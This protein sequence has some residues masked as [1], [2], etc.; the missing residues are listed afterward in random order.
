MVV[1]ITTTVTVETKKK[2]EN[3]KLRG[4]SIGNVLIQGI[5]KIEGMPQVLQRQNELETENNK[6]KRAIA[7]MQQRILDLEMEE[8]QNGKVY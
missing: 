4:Y 8:R 2:L 7:V 1:P 5:D 6:L 3:L